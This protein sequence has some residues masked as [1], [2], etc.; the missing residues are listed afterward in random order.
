MPILPPEPA[1][2]PPGLFTEREAF[3]AADRQWWVLHVRPRQEKSLARGLCE[4]ELAFY[5][6][7]T[8]RRFRLRG[9]VL[10]S[11]LPLFGG[12]VFLLANR[13]ERLAA[14]SGRRVVQTLP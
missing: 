5:L 2:F 4:K 7:L 14:L 6:P 9:R 11:L 12:Y 13:D 10:T 3:Q 1:Q 8:R